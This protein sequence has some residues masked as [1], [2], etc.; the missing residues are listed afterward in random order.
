MMVKE[1]YFEMLIDLHFFDPR[2]S[3]KVV[4]GTLSACMYG[5]MCP[6]LG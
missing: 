1:I 4:F 3:K 2:D 5:R 6:F